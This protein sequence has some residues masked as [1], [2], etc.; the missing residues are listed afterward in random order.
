MSETTQTSEIR[1]D[2]LLGKYKRGEVEAEPW[3]N[4]MRVV[5][6]GSLSP[7]P[8]IR[9][10]LSPSKPVTS[11]SKYI[12]HAESLLNLPNEL[13]EQICFELHPLEVAKCR[14]LCR[15]INDLVDGSTELQL[16]IDLAID[17][18]LVRDR[19]IDS[20]KK[21]KKFNDKKKEALENMNYFATWK[22]FISRQDRGHFEICDGI[23]A[24][25]LA[26]DPDSDGFGT[27]IYRELLPPGPRRKGGWTH[28]LENLSIPVTTFSFWLQGDL[29][30]LVE[31]RPNKCRRIHFRTISTNEVHPQS[32]VPYIDMSRT[33]FPVW[34]N[35]NT[36]SY[37]DLV[38]FSFCDTW[39]ERR[40]GAG[41]VIDCRTGQFI[42][43]YTRVTD[44]A[45]LSRD[46]VLLLFN[47]E[48]DYG[49]ALAV[50]SLKR[51]QIICK[52]RFPYQLPFRVLFLKRPESLFGDNCHSSAAKLLTPD[53]LVNILGIN[54]KL[55]EGPAS[56]WSCVVLSLDRF[57]NMYKS[58]LESC[59]G[60]DSFD[61]E[62]W[63]PTVTRWLPKQYSNP[64]GNRSIFGSRMIA[65]GPPNSLDAQSDSSSCLVLLDFN[66]RPIQRDITFESGRTS[67]GI[68]IHEETTWEDEQ[69]GLKV[70]SS[71]PYRVF[72]APHFPSGFDFR[73]DGSTIIGKWYGSYH[74][75]SF[76]PP[77]SEEP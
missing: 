74:F 71:L 19:G 10:D 51:Q 35:C 30:V 32:A 36:V 55:E 41:F 27:L 24:Q 40:L 7:I 54:F 72:T 77:Q 61:W 48:E 21:A 50:Y 67:H 9:I 53:P 26:R 37:E 42:M 8:D 45:F 25:S 75:Y 63:G 56:L 29:Q 6:E 5:N 69:V 13:L 57:Q 31:P 49:T 62:E 39:T 66:P 18:C 46:E 28:T 68:V 3:T 11:N 17:G 4:P 52:C 64:T 20:I 38:A 60:R 14:R 47:G 44:I 23:F 59:T 76:L 22:E 16:R 2:G 58:L 33:E 1:I 73:F 12:G 70:K 43:P 34:T 15:R 65:W